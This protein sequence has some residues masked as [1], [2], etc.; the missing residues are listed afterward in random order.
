MYTR[1]PGCLGSLEGRVAGAALALWTALLTHH[2][3][4]PELDK[5]LQDPRCAPAAGKFLIPL[6][7]LPDF[8]L[9]IQLFFL[10]QKVIP[11]I[12]SHSALYD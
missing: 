9:Q 6:I 4:L 5:C 1:V 7:I 2:G 8:P 3:N 12:Y 11:K 10:I